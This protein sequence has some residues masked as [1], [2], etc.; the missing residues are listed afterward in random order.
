MSAKTDLVYIPIEPLAERY[1][2]Q[3]YNKFPPLF[4]E[5]GFDVTVIDGKPLVEGEIKVG[6]FLDINSTTHY[7][8]SQLQEI[9]RLFNEGKVAQGTIF[10]F[11]DVEF[12]GLEAVRLL[13]TMNGIKV[14]MVGFLH[15]ASYTKEDAFSVAA[16]Y[17]KYT[18]VGWLAALDQ[19]YVGSEYHKQQVIKLRLAPVNALELADR[20]HVT[21]NPVFD[22]AYDF[23]PGVQKK[24]KMLLTNRFDPEKRPR[25]TLELFERLKDQG[26]A[27]WE[28]VVT[29]GRK[30]LR[31]D[32][33]DVAYAYSLQR[34]GYITIKAGLTK[35]EYHRELAE[36]WVVVTHSIEENYGYCVAEAIHYG[37]H[38]L[39][40]V[41]LS[42]E[43]F[44]DDP[45][46]F[47]SHAEDAFHKARRLQAIYQSVVFCPE[48]PYQYPIQLD[49]QGVYRIMNLLQELSYQ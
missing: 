31:G 44:T 42:H 15:A 49:R 33:N 5:R 23:F 2:E 36:A 9:S 13:A 11:G 25:Q 27:D 43:E 30:E 26:A 32:F 28:F 17:Q 47:F 3:W 20:I 1:T 38:P 4:K 18:E 48:I 22:G 6:A 35:T 37:A 24:R 21:K 12:W 14:Y 8:W 16:P 34:R 45:N 10:F 40:R 46:F 29:T 19:V 7:K 39:M 41:G